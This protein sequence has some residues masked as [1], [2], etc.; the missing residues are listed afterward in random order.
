MGSQLMQRV[1]SWIRR[2]VQ[3][4]RGEL[5]QDVLR[6]RGLRLG[7]DVYVG[8]RTRF[9]HGFLWLISVGDNTTISANVD[10]LAH[11][12]AMKRI[13]GYTQIAPVSIGS[14]VY[15]GARA[16]VL[17]GVTIGDGAIVGA[18]SVVRRDVP[19]GAV[20]AGNP[21]RIIGQAHEF[22]E[23]HR[24]MLAD[25]PTYPAKGWTFAGNITAENQ[26]RMLS[27]LRDGPG[28]VE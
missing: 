18:G 27:D 13:V 12:A 25:R 5:S 14:N 4:L 24:R 3:R 28:Y 9:D 20:V 22:V 17:P 2:P 7:E 21:A 10:I 11:D 16:V 26:E 8:E 19:S 15:I 23:R 1:R 6:K